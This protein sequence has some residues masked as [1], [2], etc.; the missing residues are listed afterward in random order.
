MTN[1]RRVKNSVK[2]MSV[3]EM[4]KAIVAVMSSITCDY[5]NRYNGTCSGLHC[6][7]TP[8]EE[9]IAEWLKSKASEV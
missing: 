2:N 4:A 7:M 3:E 5:C 1:Y 9:I 6:A 8:N